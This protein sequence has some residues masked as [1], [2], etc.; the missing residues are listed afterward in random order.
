MSQ[1]RMQAKIDELKGGADAGSS[2]A[3]RTTRNAGPATANS[4]SP[5]GLGCSPD[6][7]AAAHAATAAARERTA[8]LEADLQ[9]RQES[10]LR[11]ERAYKVHIEEMEEELEAARADRGACLEKDPKMSEIRGMHARI[12]SNVGQVQGRTSRILQEQVRAVAD[13]GHHVQRCV[14]AG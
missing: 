14:M 8:Q 1:L 7:L 5:G 10:Y 2:P 9:R 3:R 12:L 4:G 11:R 6:E 13:R